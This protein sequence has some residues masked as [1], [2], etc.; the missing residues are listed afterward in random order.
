MDRNC[1]CA[2]IFMCY[3]ILFNY[4]FNVQNSISRQQ[5]PTT[6][7]VQAAPKGARQWNTVTASSQTKN[8]WTNSG[9]EVM[10]V[11]QNQEVY[12]QRTH[13]Q[14]V[15]KSMTNSSFPPGSCAPVAFRFKFRFRNIA[16]ST[17][18]TRDR[19]CNRTQ[20]A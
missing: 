15:R 7:C 16:L 3:K 11:Q 4:G 19:E 1:D 20:N 6:G 18:D 9:L 5:T 8:C 13:P 14:R 17:L 2:T 12:Q 10:T